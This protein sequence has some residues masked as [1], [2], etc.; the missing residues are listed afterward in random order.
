VTIRESIATLNDTGDIRAK[1]KSRLDPNDWRVV[2]RSAVGIFKTPLTTDQGRRMGSREF[3]LH[4]RAACGGRLVIRT[5]AL[6]S[7]VI[8]DEENRA[9][10]VE[11]LPGE[12]LYR[13]D[14]RHGDRV[15]RSRVRVQAKREVVLAGGAFNTPQLLKLSGIGPRSELRAHGIEPR[16]DLPGV[17]E[18]LQD[19]YEV[20]VVTRMNA[21]FSTVE[22]AK[23]R[24]PREGETPDPQF[25]AWMKGEGPY[26]TNGAVISLVERSS[27]EQAEPDLFIFGLLGR[28]QGYYP[29]YSN[30]IE[31]GE[32]YFTWAILKG[33]SNN[34]AG[35]VTLRSANP[36]DVP[37]INFHYFEEGAG[38]NWRDDLEA[39]A[40]GVDTV[41]RITA[42]AKGVIEEEIVPGPDVSS[43]DE[44]RDFIKDNA[45]GHHASCTCKM[46]PA[47]DSMAVVDSRF[48]VHGAKNLRVVDASVFPRIPGFFI[49]SSVYMISEKA[50]DV[51]MEDSGVTS[52]ERMTT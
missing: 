9:T 37:D 4:A 50:S 25:Q 10:G 22:G 1:A 15:S 44:V 47:T 2:E 11:Y 7:R 19:R 23:F 29:G 18:N 20:C 3:L 33:H 6:V 51:I 41:R 38:T 5:N 45:W 8:L 14:P 36:Q 16:V 21:A 34:T 35:R 12:S 39:V 32:N 26:T 43:P 17:G 49:V 31:P 40:T 24:P 13:A 28:F 52:G 48:R 27:P 46:G 42:R 30:D